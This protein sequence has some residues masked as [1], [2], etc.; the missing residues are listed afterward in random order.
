MDGG[1]AA[2]AAVQHNAHMNLRAPD[3]PAV[4][5]FNTTRA[6]ARAHTPDPQTQEPL[7]QWTEVSDSS[8]RND[9][10]CAPIG[11]SGHTLPPPLWV[12]SLPTV[13]PYLPAG[14]GE[15]LALPGSLLAGVTFT[16]AQ[17]P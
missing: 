10:L 3:R 13:A 12:W 4:L 2:A 6:R 9:A 16:P 11:D 7:S 17:P 1:V 14:D 15:C 8:R 5:L